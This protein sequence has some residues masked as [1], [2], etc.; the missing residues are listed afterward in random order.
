MVQTYT[1]EGLKKALR[2]NVSEKTLEHYKVQGWLTADHV[3]PG[4]IR[5]YTMASVEDAKRKSLESAEPQHTAECVVT[6][7]FIAEMKWKTIEQEIGISPTKQPI[8]RRAYAK[9]TKHNLSAA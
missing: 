1:L 5:R 3:T 8:K 4:G 7:S 9:A 6:E 2:G